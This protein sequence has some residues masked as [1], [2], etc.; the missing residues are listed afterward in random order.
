LSACLTGE[1]GQ[2]LRDCD[3]RITSSLSK[4]TQLLKSR[5]G[6]T[7]RA[8]KFRTEL[9]SRIKQPGETLEKLH[10]DIRRCMAL[11]F[12]DVDAKA[13]GR[14]ASDYFIGA[15]N[16]PDFSLKVSERNPKTLHEALFAVQ[17]IEVWLKDASKARHAGE[18]KIH[19]R[20]D[21]YVRGTTSISD[22]VVDTDA[23]F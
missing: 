14:L 12:S 1:A 2:V 10:Q 15:L 11:A 21:R 22:D 8:D 17:Q 18:E 9:R 4:L 6:G 23:T 7:A 5:F 20:R 19:R 3:A 13:R 16:D